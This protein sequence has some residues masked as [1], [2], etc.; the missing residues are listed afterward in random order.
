MLY[1][2]LGGFFGYITSYILLKC[3]NVSFRDR[4]YTPSN[5]SLGVLCCTIMGMIYGFGFDTSQL[6]EGTHPF[7]K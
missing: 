1:G 6:L 3:M 7:N 2:T 5:G 4:P